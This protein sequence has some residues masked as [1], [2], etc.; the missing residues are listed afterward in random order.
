MLSRALSINNPA[1]R[2]LSSKFHKEDENFDE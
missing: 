2:G 1:I